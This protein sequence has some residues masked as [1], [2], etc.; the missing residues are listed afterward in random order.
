[1]ARKPKTRRSI[2]VKGLTYQRLDGYCK[3]EG[4]SVSGYLE[5]ILAEKLTAAGVPMP[6]VIKK[7]PKQ[8]EP[9]RAEDI[10]SQHWTF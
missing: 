7:K 4:R 2:S 3:A 6:T 10:D 9:L 5:E 8:A 1:M